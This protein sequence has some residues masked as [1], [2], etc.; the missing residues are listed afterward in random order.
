MLLW[1]GQKHSELSVQ[2]LLIYLKLLIYNVQTVQFQQFRFTAR[3]DEMSLKCSEASSRLEVR[4]WD[5]FFSGLKL[6]RT[7]SSELKGNIP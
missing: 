3:L 2:K 6:V 4:F 1:S 5:N 7:L